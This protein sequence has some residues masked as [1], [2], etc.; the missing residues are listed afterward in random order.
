MSL[1]DLYEK[2]K[3]QI[4]LNREVEPLL[5]MDKDDKKFDLF[6]SMYAST[7]HVAEIKMFLPF[8]I[9]LD[10]F[11]R[12]VIKEDGAHFEEAPQ[13]Q[14]PY[15][16]HPHYPQHYGQN[17]YE[18]KT[19]NR[20]QAINPHTR[21]GQHPMASSASLPHHASLN[22]LVWGYPN[23]GPYPYPNNLL[24]P[25]PQEVALPAAPNHAHLPEI[26]TL[27]TE[28][29]PKQ[30]SVLNVEDLCDSLTRIV[31][32]NEARIPEYQQ[33]IRKNNINGKV[34]AHCAMEDLK[35]ELHMSFGD[36]ELFKMVIVCLREAEIS[37]EEED[38]ITQNVRFGVGARLSLDGPISGGGGQGSLHLGDPDHR[39]A[40]PVSN[41]N[42]DASSIRRGNSFSEST[43]PSPA[44]LT[45]I[46]T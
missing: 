4:P 20:R 42:S 25:P 6:L 8:T 19:L 22:P 12:K 24:P 3:P 46:I 34:L 45:E 9:N 11:I 30:L 7:L 5:D 44:I 17:P 1:K 32:L 33:N 26:E 37:A 27:L 36:W 15:P 21:R 23:P 16:S 29:L 43:F 40:T 38:F 2:I 35:K 10:P 18:D 28:K 39:P 41:Q 14:Q 13:T 31:S